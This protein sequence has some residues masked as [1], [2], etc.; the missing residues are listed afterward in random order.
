MLSVI[1]SVARFITEY[2]S[3]YQ[4]N[5]PPTGSLFKS[6]LSHFHHKHVFHITHEPSLYSSSS[7]PHAG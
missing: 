5:P 1:L 2:G 4:I 3:P 7:S 6:F